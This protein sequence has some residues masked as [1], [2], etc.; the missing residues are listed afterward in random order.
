MGTV[1]VLGSTP[2][3]SRTKYAINASIM[4]NT[5]KDY[6]GWNSYIHIYI[7]LYLYTWT[8]AAKGFLKNS[9]AKKK[10]GGGGLLNQSRNQLK[11]LTGLRTGHSHFKGHSLKL[12]LVNSHKCDTRKQA[13]EV[14]SRSL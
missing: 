2:H 13:S 4:Q 12:G 10:K 6:K 3:Y 9:P 1:P 11:I 14:A 8:T 5:E 7:C